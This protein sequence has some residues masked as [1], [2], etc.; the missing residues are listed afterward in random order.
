M[1]PEFSG[2]LE[3]AAGEKTPLGENCVLGRSAKCQVVVNTAKASRRHAMIYR[4]GRYQFGL[5]DLGSA[6]GTRLNGKHVSQ[7]CRLSDG[8]RIE[9]AGST[10]VF[11]QSKQ[12]F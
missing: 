8:D 9:I 3:S 11:R 10:F 6:N 12:A 5:V 7:P 4:Q 2:W 1:K